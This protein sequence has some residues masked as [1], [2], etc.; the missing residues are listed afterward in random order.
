MKPPIVCVAAITVQDG[1]PKPDARNWQYT[2]NRTPAI[3]G[4]SAASRGYETKDR[5]S[6]MYFDFNLKGLIP[7]LVVM[8]I[9]SVFGVWKLASLVAW[10]ASHLR[11]E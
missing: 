10:V 5:R 3:C 9:L 8:A 4:S 6:L 7:A 2:P 1:T 11:W